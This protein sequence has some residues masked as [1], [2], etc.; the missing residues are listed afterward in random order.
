MTA[1]SRRHPGRHSRP[2]AWA[3][4]GSQFRRYAITPDGELTLLGSI[5]VSA[6]AGVGA[7]DPGL[8]PDG[9]FLFPNESR[10]DALGAFA[11]SSRSLTELPSS[12][13]ALPAGATPAGIAVS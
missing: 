3:P 8:S 9:R 11:V 12:P 5:T 6:T 7:V 1:G 13:T 2:R 4:F 10:I